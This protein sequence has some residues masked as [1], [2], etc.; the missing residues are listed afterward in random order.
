MHAKI[1]PAMNKNEDEIADVL[2]RLQ[3]RVGTKPER[4]H[5]DRGGEFNLIG[6]WWAKLQ[7]AYSGRTAGYRPQANGA[8]ENSHKRIWWAIDALLKKLE[9]RDRDSSSLNA[10]DVCLY[11]E[12]IVNN[13]VN[14][15]I[16]FTP[17]Q[18]QQGNPLI[19]PLDH[20]AESLFG[21][22]IRPDDP[23]VIDAMHEEDDKRDNELVNDEQWEDAWRTSNCTPEPEEIGKHLQRLDRVKAKKSSKGNK[24]QGLTKFDYFVGTVTAVTSVP[25]CSNSD[26]LGL[27]GY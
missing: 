19:E 10:V 14:R 6:T 23:N 21:L 12:H 7:E 25:V 16:G 9:E 24:R 3:V 1:D 18:V 13:S 26:V 20:I 15:S 4:T 27:M 17:N 2:L 8:N 22:E 5:S 11:L